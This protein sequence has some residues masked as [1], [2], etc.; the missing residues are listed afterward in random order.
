MRGPLIYQGTPHQSPHPLMLPSQAMRGPLMTPLVPSAE[1][2]GM[3]LFGIQKKYKGNTA[4]EARRGDFGVSFFR[5]TRA[6]QRKPG[7]Q[8]A[9]GKNPGHVFPKHKG[10]P[11]REARR[12]K[13]GGMFSRNTKGIRRAKRAGGK[14]GACFFSEIQR[15]SGAR[16]APGVISGYFFQSTA[17]TP[18]L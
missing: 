3:F 13:S 8:S 10:S 5:N 15:K 4:R 11:A 7:A 18:P 12:G 9:P 2:P 16:S 14:P 1:N 17:E 6:I